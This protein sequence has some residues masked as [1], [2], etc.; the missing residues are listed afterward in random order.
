MVTFTGIGCGGAGSS[1]VVCRWW[2]FV[3][4][5][6]FRTSASGLGSVWLYAQALPGGDAGVVGSGWPPA[7]VV[8]TAGRAA[9]GGGYGRCLW[10]R[11]PDSGLASHA[12]LS[13][14]R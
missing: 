13:G 2:T 10:Q 12:D 5:R 14:R 11:R 6:S 1:L 8:L 4:V 9:R 3:V 7:M